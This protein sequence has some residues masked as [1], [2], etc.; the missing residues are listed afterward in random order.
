MVTIEQVRTPAEREAFLEFPFRLYAD[1]PAWV[2]PIR[3]WVRKRLS[4]KNPFFKEATL[5]LFVAKRGSEIVGTVSTL[6]DTRWERL[7]D[8][9]TSFY[10]FFET[11]N[12]PEVS[13]ALLGAAADHARGWGS[14]TLRGP[15]NL[16]RI[17]EVGVTVEGHA[18]PPPMLASHHA[19][20]VQALVEAEGF[21]KHHDV[22]AYDTPLRDEQGNPRSLPQHLQAKADSVDLPGLVVR[23]ARWRSMANDLT[24]AH[25][26]YTKAFETVPDII[27]MPREQFVSL[28]RGMLAF[29]NTQMLQ[30][31]LLDG[32][33]IAFAACLPELNEAVTKARGHILPTGWARFAAGLRQIRTASFKLIGVLEEHRHT[34]VHAVLI[35]HVVD[36]LRAAGY[37]RLEASL[38]DERNKPMR[39]VVEGAGCTI[40]R[41]YRIYDKK[42]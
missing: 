20:Y 34:G 32:E 12:D 35:Q 26:V 19:P 3:E 38:I 40:Y 9:K 14:E 36:G 18:V 42:L 15:R 21:E 11:V 27:P 28:G 1:D 23:R 41:R 33:P 37:E 30:I 4:P 24:L 6:R 29:S 5:D 2:P 8:E 13:K 31:A 22:L 25:R 7:K 10:G 39:R 16:T 17:E